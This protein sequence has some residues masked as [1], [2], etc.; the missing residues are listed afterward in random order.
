MDSSVQLDIVVKAFASLDKLSSILVA[1][2]KIRDEK[3]LRNFVADFNSRA[4]FYDFLDVGFG[5][6]RADQKIRGKCPLLVR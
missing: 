6:E 2:G 1:K 4:S 5:R 3:H